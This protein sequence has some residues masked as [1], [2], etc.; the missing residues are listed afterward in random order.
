MYG[1]KKLRR[2]QRASLG[3]RTLLGAPGIT[4]RSKKRVWEQ[5]VLQKGRGGDVSWILGQEGLKVIGSMSEDHQCV[6]LGTVSNL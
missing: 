5:E 3:A 1:N 6:V 2:E 4:T